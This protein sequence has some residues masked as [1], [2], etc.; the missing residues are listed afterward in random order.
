MRLHW[1]GFLADCIHIDFHAVEIV[2]GLCEK[3]KIV[4]DVADKISFYYFQITGYIIIEI[5]HLSWW[6]LGAY[7]KQAFIQAIVFF[8]KYLRH[9]FQ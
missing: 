1:Q 9:L 4:L 5:F 3:I 8:E 6:A 2:K 7:S